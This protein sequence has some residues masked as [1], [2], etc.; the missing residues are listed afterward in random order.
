MTILRSLHLLGEVED[1]HK[2]LAKI[3]GVLEALREEDGLCNEVIVR[4]GHCHRPEQLLQVVRQ[5]GP[6]S[7]ALACWV[8]C[9]KDARVGVDIN[10]QNSGLIR[11]C[12][13]T[14]P[15]GGHIYLGITVT[16]MIFIKV[17]EF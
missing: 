5:F 15:C 12:N 2:F 3:L 6:A 9:Y 4:L 14:G 11:Q 17:T 1:S 8:H 13:A 10:L 16:I 7:V